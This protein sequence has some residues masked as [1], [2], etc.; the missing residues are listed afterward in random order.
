[1]RSRVSVRACP[2][3]TTGWRTSQRRN[4]R[5]VTSPSTTVSSSAR[6]SR[7]SAAARSGPQAMIFASIGS[8]RPPISSPISIPASTRTPSPAGQ[9]S[10]STRPVAGRKPSSA[11][12]A[13]SRTST[14]W[15]RATTSTV[16]KPRRS[17][18]GDPKLVGNEVAAGDE[19][20]HRMLDLEAG[21]H[22]E[23][24]GHAVVVDDELARARAD[25]SDRARERQRGLTQPRRGGRHPLPATA[26]PR[27]P[28]GGVAGS[29]SRARR[30][31][32]RR[33]R[34][35]TG[36]GSRCGD[37]LRP[38]VRGSGGRHRM[39]PRASRRAAASAS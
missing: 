25:V 1:M 21:V 10:V 6:A 23:E 7:S 33:R 37:H 29:S 32:R 5:L 4:R 2:A 31:A 8:N 20:G 30:D 26:P 22:L 19:L 16:S 11:S 3:S 36:P 18:D 17:P 24:R 34:H 38:A 15:P 14:A 9:R 13:Y 35:R 28:S 39:L 27:G 12:S